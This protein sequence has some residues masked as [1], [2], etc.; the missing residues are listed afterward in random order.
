M[1][2]IPYNVD[3]KPLPAQEWAGETQSALSPEA[4]MSASRKTPVD[5]LEHPSMSHQDSVG[6]IPGAYPTTPSDEIAS[7]GFAAGARQLMPASEDIEK[8]ITNFGQTVKQYL[9]QTVASHLPSVESPSRQQVD[10]TTVAEGMEG[11]PT[12]NP[13]IQNR[14]SIDSFSSSPQVAEAQG[15]QD[16]SNRPA[17]AI[18]SHEVDNVSP[19]KATQAANISSGRSSDSVSGLPIEGHKTTT[20]CGAQP[21]QVVAMPRVYALGG[22]DV[23]GRSGSIP[24]GKVQVEGD[25]AHGFDSKSLSNTSSEVSAG[26]SPRRSRF[27]DKIK[28][29]AKI[30]TG[31]L[32]HNARKIEEGKRMLGR[33]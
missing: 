21:P 33:V 17:G 7:L 13:P 31:K 11:Y 20:T 23:D 25:T 30:I 8:G 32:S 10:D 2:S 15:D 27:R 5:T 14:A 22:L 6:P 16:L 26:D 1:S 24:D 18:I 28:G 3:P 19:E 12:F 9:P 29:E 4:S